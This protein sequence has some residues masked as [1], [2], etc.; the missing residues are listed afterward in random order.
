MI[1]PRYQEY[2][3]AQIP[4]VEHAD[5]GVLRVIAGEVEGVRGPVETH[6]PVT[7]VHATLPPGATAAVATP[8]AH[9]AMTFTFEGTGDGE[10]AIFAADGDAVELR[11]DGTA[12]QE[13]L[14]LAGEPLREPVA[15]YGPFVMSTSEEIE[16]AINDY[17]S[18]Q[19]GA[20][21]R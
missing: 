11:N 15:R 7:Y 13:V 3:A 10:L 19:F 16:Q 12:V 2:S 4:R 18:G 14:V 6:S 5:G 21:A 8:A 1:D 9:Q 17:R 20:I